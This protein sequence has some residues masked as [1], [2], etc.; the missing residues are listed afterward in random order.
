MILSIKCLNFLLCCTFRNYLPEL[1]HLLDQHFRPTIPM[2]KDYISLV[3]NHETAMLALPAPY[4][5]AVCLNATAAATP[6]SIIYR[7]LAFVTILALLPEIVS[8]FHFSF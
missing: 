8:D 1:L 5:A 4:Y 3:L 7:V 2:W 6:F